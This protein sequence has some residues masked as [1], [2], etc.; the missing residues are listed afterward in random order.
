VDW[1]IREGERW[2]LV[3]P[4]GAGKT[5]LLSLILAD[6]PQAYAN[7]FALFGRDRG[8]GESIWEI[9]Q[10][11]GWVAPELH[12]YY[13]VGATC[14]DVVCSGFFDS[15]GLYRRCAPEHRAAAAGWM[16]RLGISGC[17][18]T[19]FARLSE[20]Q[21][22]LALVARALVKHPRLLVLDEPCQS[23]DRSNRDLVLEAIDDL[24][25]RL[26]ATIIYVTHRSDELP[27]TITHVIRLHDG[28][29][30]ETCQVSASG[31]RY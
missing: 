16:A 7:R 28:L 15:V 4:N 31:P 12:L 22:R 30:T 25:I 23:L 5:T 6:N 21:Q 24:T 3:G 1:T 26:A 29:V 14:Q 17:R 10:Q 13:P 19:P 11:L 18:D 8:S 27:S 9:K 20:G 2:A